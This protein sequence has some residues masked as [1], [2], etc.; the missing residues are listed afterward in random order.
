M[1]QTDRHGLKMVRRVSFKM[2]HMVQRIVRAAAMRAV[3]SFGKI[4]SITYRPNRNEGT[5]IRPDPNT[6]AEIENAVNAA[7][8]RISGL[9]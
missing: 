4:R 5:E 2:Q 1:R 7:A 9:L 8:S 3:K 6:F